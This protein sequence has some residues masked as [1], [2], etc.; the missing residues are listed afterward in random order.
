MLRKWDKLPESMQTD[1]VHQ[2][3]DVLKKKR[4][5]LLV[6]RLFDIFA[7]LLMLIILSPIFL[8]LALAIKADSKGPVFFRQ[9]RVTQ[10]GKPFRIFK[11][12]SM[13][14]NADK[15]GE[16]ITVGNDKRVT[17]TGRFIRKFRLDEISQLIDILRGTMTFVG[18]RPEV[19][20][21]V[22][23]YTPEMMATLL[24]PAG[25]TSLA[26]IYYKDEAELLDAA[27]DAE[28]A[29]INDVLPAKMKY[30]LI[31]IKQFSL[32]KD[33]KVMVMTVFAVLGADFSK[34]A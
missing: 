3:Y 14:C 27:E 32:F 31:A 16:Q 28:Q 10:Y 4:V 13:V 21:Y 26:S 30:N 18:T 33:L 23:K 19:S 17:R 11:F 8:L 2:Y 6:K 15:P 5:A 24:L 29:Y 22:A 20:G 25:V 7:S 34:E 1:E 12:R 9:E